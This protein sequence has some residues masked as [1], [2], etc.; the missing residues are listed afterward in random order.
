MTKLTWAQRKEMML[1]GQAPKAGTAKGR[2]A[3]RRKEEVRRNN[4]RRPGGGIKR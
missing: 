2:K 1:R 3:K 4:S